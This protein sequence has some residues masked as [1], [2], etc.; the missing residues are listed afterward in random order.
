M[1]AQTQEAGN[2]WATPRGETAANWIANYQR[3]LQSRQRT[4]IS[5]IV[6]RLAPETVFEV[7]SHCGPNLIRLAADYPALKC[8]GIDANTEAVEAGR[9]WVERLGFSDRIRL[10]VGRV[11]EQTLGL[12]TGFADV[13]LSCYTL[14][15]IAPA[16]LDAVLYDMGRLATKAVILA[17]PMSDTDG[18]APWHGAFHSGYQE[19]AHNYQ[20]ATKWLNTWHGMT[21]TRVP[22]TPPIDRL[23]A[24]L[25]AVRDGA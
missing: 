13:V 19:W 21:L 9:S 23:N 11:P 12:A 22:V 15:Y 18:Q 3:S 4:L 20:A 7:G 17:E 8:L 2:W 16:D 25:V 6:G 1:H 5:E 10:S 24:I 14:A